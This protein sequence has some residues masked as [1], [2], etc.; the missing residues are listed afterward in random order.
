MYSFDLRPLGTL[1]LF[2]SLFLTLGCG[3]DDDDL[4]D[5]Q[6]P[7]FNTAL[8]DYFPYEPGDVI[9]FTGADTF[10]IERSFVVT[11]SVIFGD[12]TY[13]AFV[14]T[15]VCNPFAEFLGREVNLESTVLNF[16]ITDLSNTDSGGATITV[17]ISDRVAINAYTQRVLITENGEVGAG[18]NSTVTEIDELV[19]RDSLYNDVVRL[20]LVTIPD[21]PDQFFNDVRSIWIARGA[22]II[23]FEDFLL[24]AF[25]LNP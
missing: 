6:C 19:V 5:V 13:Q 25:E 8:S 7:P 12:T 11:N 1:L 18:L 16:L 4:F 10:A 2:V 21:L 9:R 15:D 24:G 23:R 17:N 3:N 22:G 20:D 14:A